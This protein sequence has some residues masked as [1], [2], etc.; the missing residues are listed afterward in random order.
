LFSDELD[1]VTAYRQERFVLEPLNDEV[2]S[3]EACVFVTQAIESLKESFRL[4]EA[5]V[6]HLV[7]SVYRHYN[8]FIL[9]KIRLNQKNLLKRFC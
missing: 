1:P 7:Y 9:N 3:K 2:V 4:E 8:D 5:D 6:F